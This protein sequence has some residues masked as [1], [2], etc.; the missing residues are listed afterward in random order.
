MKLSDSLYLNVLHCCSSSLNLKIQIN[1]GQSFHVVSF[2]LEGRNKKME[3]WLN[4]S[5]LNWISCHHYKR[6]I[7]KETSSRPTWV[8]NREWNI[9]FFHPWNIFVWQKLFIEFSMRRGRLLFILVFSPRSCLF[10]SVSCYPETPSNY[11]FLENI[12]WKVGS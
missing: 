6:Q 9:F 4:S 5:V 1:F 3:K 11:S 8:L 10:L 2:L 7:R 12:L